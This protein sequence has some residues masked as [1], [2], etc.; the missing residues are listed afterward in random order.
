MKRANATV[1]N[2][3]CWCKMEC[4]CN[5]CVSF[6]SPDERNRIG[7][8]FSENNCRHA[9][10]YVLVKNKTLLLRSE[11]GCRTRSFCSCFLTLRA[12]SAIFGMEARGL[13]AV[14]S[15]LDAQTRR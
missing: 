11:S 6:R 15:T 13:S 2:E 4:I 9:D 3:P 14:Y 8:I 1:K 10:L 5:C 12:R 7:D